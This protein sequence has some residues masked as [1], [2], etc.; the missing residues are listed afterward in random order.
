[1]AL[2]VEMGGV[3]PPI[4]LYNLFAVSGTTGVPVINL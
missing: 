4:G 1:M 2:A 3:M